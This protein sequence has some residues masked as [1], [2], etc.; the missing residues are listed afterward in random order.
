MLIVRDKFCIISNY[1]QDKGYHEN[2]V[3]FDKLNIDHF[4]NDFN[5]LF[6]TAKICKSKTEAISFYRNILDYYGK[7]QSIDDKSTIHSEILF[8]WYDKSLR[9]D[10]VKLSDSE[11]LEYT[12]IEHPGS[13]III[14]F[15]SNGEVLMVDQYRY[16][17]RMNSI[18]FPAGGINSGESS[19][20]AANRELMEETGYCAS[21]LIKLGEF[22]TSNSLTDEKI[23]VY[24][25]IDLKETSA[26]A[27]QDETFKIRKFKEHYSKLVNDIHEGRIKDGPTIIATQFLRDYLEK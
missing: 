12:Y 27:S 6:E 7:Y 18:E 4:I 24:L 5:Q 17:I 22:Y 23:E 19:T 16:P 14:P 25:A 8:H 21:E 2:R 3:Y 26:P 15:F 20:A 11:E 9:K 1:S 13:I 10:I